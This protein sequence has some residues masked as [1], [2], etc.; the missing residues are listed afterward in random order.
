MKKTLFIPNLPNLLEIQFSSFYW[1][2]S[3]GLEKELTLFPSII[4]SHFDIEFRIYANEFI[5]KKRKNRTRLEDKKDKLTHAVRIYLP[6]QVKRYNTEQKITVQYLFIGELPLMTTTGSFIVNG[7]ERVIVNQIIK[8]PGL[9]YKLEKNKFLSIPTLT[10]VAKRGSWLKFELTP[11]GC[12]VKVDKDKRIC[13]LDFLHQIGLNDK[14]ISLAIKFNSILYQY[15]NLQ[16]E[17]KIENRSK[18]LEDAEV[19]ILVDN[20]FNE[21]YYELGTIG[22]LLINKRLNLNRDYNIKTLTSQDILAILDYFLQLKGFLSDDI[23]NLQTKR[24]RSIG[25]VLETQFHVGLNRLKRELSNSLNL[26]DE[27]MLLS[28][29]IFN[30]RSVGGAF[31]EFFVSSQLSQYMDQTNPLSELS[32]K[33]RISAIGPGGLNADRVKL[34]ARDIHPSQYGRICP[35]EAPEGKNVGIVSALACYAKINFNGFIETPYFQV[36]QGKI[37]YDKP[38]VYLA[39]NEEDNVK[40]SSCDVK[41]TMNGF[42]TEDIVVARFNHE[43]LTTSSKEVDFISISPIQIISIAATLIPFLEHNDANRALMASNMQ[44]QAVPLLYPQKP[45]VGTGLELQISSDSNLVVIAIK[46][47]IVS[48]VSSQQ[49]IIKTFDNLENIYL[50][51]KYE[52]S[53]QETCINQKPIVWVGEEIKTG[54]IIADGAATDD[55]ELALGHNLTVA[56]MPWEGYNYEDSILI[57]DRVVINNLLTSIHIEKYQTYLRETENGYERLTRELP[58]MDSPVISYLDENGIIY[59]DT[60]VQPGDILIGKVTPTTEFDQF[61]EARLLKAI[62]GFKYPNVIDNSLKVS[63]GTFGRVIDTKILKEDGFEN[64]IRVFIAEIRKIKVGDKIAGRHGNKGVVSKI[65]SQQDMPFLPDGTIVDIILNPLGVPSRMN[66][67]Q[68][69]ECLLGFAADHLNKRYK[70]LPFDEIYQSEASRVLINQKLSEAS[71]KQNKKWLYNSYSPGKIFLT[72][73]RTGIKFDNPILVGRSYIL[74]L[75]HLVDDKIQARSTGPYSLITQQPVGGKSRKGGQRFGEMEV[76]ALEAYGCAYILQELL[77]IKSDD[78]QGRNQVLNSLVFGKVI[79]PPG[80]PESFKVLILEL[81]ALGLNIETSILH[82]QKSNELKV[83][84][85]DLMKTYE[86]KITE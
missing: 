85:I 5:L 52:R 41:T 24:L 55:G 3:Y 84:Q 74:K 48:F 29:L 25:E 10:L 16:E 38:L 34:S 83:K 8:C 54:Q 40:I 17:K 67:G 13:I 18:F 82:K 81:Q 27:L 56:Y 4:S 47:G 68:I 30:S 51:T 66:V 21:K 76:W 32:H 65:L 53:N 19:K 72:D 75:V 61:P 15:K 36:N 7:C 33:R 6:F 14:E 71:K 57:S 46:P 1:F 64:L 11:Q 77:T 28:Y 31:K 78:L 79:P 86:I 2:L 20:L 60:F 45:I 44:R 37:L 63:A 26:R 12:W 50:L 22:R 70:I 9:Y 39:A 49:I 80:I 43:F 69:Y 58:F 42:F 35:I 73:G 62:F 23:D 59:K